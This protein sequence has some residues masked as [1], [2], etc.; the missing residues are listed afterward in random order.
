[1]FLVL[2]KILRFMVYRW[3]HLEHENEGLPS[4]EATKKIICSLWFVMKTV[5]AETQSD[6]IDKIWKR[7]KK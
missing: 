1:M 6:V 3:M 2:Q 4:K 7:S 5:L